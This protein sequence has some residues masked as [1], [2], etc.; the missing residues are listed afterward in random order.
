MKVETIAKLSG[1]KQEVAESLYWHSLWL[2]KAEETA[3]INW[4]Y[5]L[6]DE[7]Y[8]MTGEIKREEKRL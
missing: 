2:R 4:L 8:R 6:K 3:Q 5:M 1:L 7:H